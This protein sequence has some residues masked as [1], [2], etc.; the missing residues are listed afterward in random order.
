M[1]R[2]SARAVVLAAAALALGV[3]LPP[4]PPPAR[5]A[6]V[7]PTI[8][9]VFPRQGSTTGGTAVTITGTNF[10]APLTVTFGGAATVQAPLVVNETTLTCVAPAHI[11]GDVDV[12]V[13]ENSDPVNL[14][15]TK[16][17]AFHY[18]SKHP[19]YVWVPRALGPASGGPDVVIVDVANLRE[20]GSLD[21]PVPP[22]LTDDKWRVTQ[23][24][25]DP[26]GA[27][28]LLATAGVPGV[29]DAGAVYVVNTAIAVGDKGGTALVGAL[30]VVEDAASLPPKLGN[31]YQLAF[32]AD[33]ATLYAAD[34]GSWSA[35]ASPLPDGSILSWDLQGFAASLTTTN[36]TPPVIQS[37]E[38]GGTL[39]LLSYDRDTSVSWGTNSS[40]KG[41]ILSRS[42]FT[43]VTCA[44]SQILRRVRLS[45]LS[46][47][48]DRQG[49][50]PFNL[51]P[52]PVVSPDAD[53]A[54]QQVTTAL[55]SPFDDDVVFVETRG[56]KTAAAGG[57]PVTDYFVYRFST[58]LDSIRD[59]PNG[60]GGARGWT[61]VHREESAVRF[62]D[63]SSLPDLARFLDRVAWPHADAAAIVT[64]PVGTGGPVSWDP[65]TGGSTAAT[66][67]TPPAAPFASLAFNDA[68]GLYYAGVDDAD[69][70]WVVFRGASTSLASTCPGG[71]TP[72]ELAIPKLDFVTTIDDG[73]KSD[74]LRVVGT[75]S[76]LVGTTADS[77]LAV[78]VDD[79]A[80]PLVH[81]IQVLPVPLSLNADRGPVFPQP[82]SFFAT[83]SEFPLPAVSG[84]LLRITE[85]AGLVPFG[86]E[87]LDCSTIPGT[88]CPPTFKGAYP[89]GSGTGYVLLLGTQFDFLA[90]PGSL[91]FRV[92]YSSADG[93]FRP[94][95]AQWRRLLRSAASLSTEERPFYA[96]LVS[97]GTGA[98]RPVSPTV[99]YHVQAGAVPTKL[100]ASPISFAPN[101][102][103]PAISFTVGDPAETA[104]YFIDVATVTGSAKDAVPPVKPIPV[105][106][107]AATY[108]DPD[109]SAS[110]DADLWRRVFDAAIQRSGT[111]GTATVEFTVRH[112]DSF[113]RV[114]RSDP[115]TVAVHKP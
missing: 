63:D 44:H 86:P 40:F 12:T 80:Q 98:F 54:V 26:N 36:F 39:P 59:K 53:G 43:L 15:D 100:K 89:D 4:L 82:D 21:L 91:R 13:A 101:A 103:P 27:F 106:F 114:L 65:A 78:L 49:A 2:P 90:V 29:S 34:G 94:S 99:C 68:T 72:P 107:D 3:A 37:R 67:F 32:S 51:A 104:D 61:P 17:G 42:G 115:F 75:G 111:A 20:V 25:F 30:P 70:G 46:L 74:S 55:P 112:V 5:A 14:K 50:K 58:G 23:V 105:V 108:A 11:A 56:Q 38:V 64:V 97:R 6:G 16:A 9:T 18:N 7:A 28:A 77:N 62:Q 10:I 87:W 85:P 84:S 102:P 66:G 31:P 71:T 113:G 110:L 41:V 93:G 22:L 48:E 79:P 73:M 1:N 57:L 8:S 95:P 109:Y 45:N 24:L 96:R 81:G 88:P 33:H 69:G 76:S 60:S 35:A 83:R 47:I 92:R 19:C 52:V